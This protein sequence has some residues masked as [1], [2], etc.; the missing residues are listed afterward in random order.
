MISLISDVA[1][2]SN[3]LASPLGPMVHMVLSV[4]ALVLGVMEYAV[5]CLRGLTREDG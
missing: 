5:L 2:G 1:S 3:V 4:L